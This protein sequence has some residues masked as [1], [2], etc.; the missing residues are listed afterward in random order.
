M[1]VETDVG[2]FVLPLVECP[3]AAEVGI[4][5]ALSRAAPAVAATIACTDLVVPAH[6]PQVCPAAD[7]GIAEG[8][9]FER[10]A[11]AG[12]LGGARH[13]VDGSHERRG[14]VDAACGAFEHLDADNLAQVDGQIH[15]V[16]ACLRV[17]DVDAVEQ[18]D[19]LFG[20]TSTDTDV[21][22]CTNG[23]TL[24][25]IDAY[26]VLQ[27]IVNTLYG[28]LRNIGTFQYSYHSRSLTTRQGRPG[29][30]HRDFLQQHLARR[31]GGSR[32]AD[33]RGCRNTLCR[34]ERERGYRQ[35]AAH[36]FTPQTGKQRV[37]LVPEMMEHEDWA[38]HVECWF[39]HVVI[40]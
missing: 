19:D 40:N 7:V 25:D 39:V 12:L 33:D 9:A 30:R 4:Q 10:H 16:V 31:R 21:S 2:V 29:A 8:A 37:A 20:S 35:D 34:G 11:G 17:A 1:P 14:A 26:G 22:L 15:R 32:V 5:T 38:L 18:E 36:H 27:Q 3:G 23:S 13:D 24:A 28:S 6:L